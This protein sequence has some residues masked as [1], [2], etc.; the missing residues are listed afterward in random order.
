MTFWV[1]KS[2]LP[3]S[4]GIRGQ[5]RDAVQVEMEYTVFCKCDFVS[6]GLDGVL[7]P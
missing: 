3:E 5:P 2:A 6:N 7:C 4:A 1:M